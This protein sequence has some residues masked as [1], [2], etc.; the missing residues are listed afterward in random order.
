[1][2]NVDLNQ[3][4]SPTREIASDEQI[5]SETLDGA[6][7][8]PETTY[9]N[10]DWHKWLGYFM[11]IPDL[12]AALTLKALF[13]VGKGY[14]TEDIHTQTILDN[15]S[16]FGKDTF[17]DILYNMQIQ[18]RIGGEA[19]A[20]I[21]RDEDGELLNLKPLDPGTIQ[22]VVDSKGI[23][24]RYEQI[25]KHGKKQSVKKFKPEDMFVMYNNRIGD[26]IHGISDIAPLE[27]T[28]IANNNSFVDVKD[29]MH[30]QSKP[31]IIFKLKTDDSTK[32]TTF[33]NKMEAALKEGNHIY[34]PDDENILSYE[35]VQLN[36]SNMVLAW[37]DDLRNSFFR[38]IGLPQIVPGA[39]GQ[40]TES[41]SKTIYLAF[42]T[43]TA[44]DQL[45]IEEQ[46]W[47]QLNLRIK[48]NSPATLQ[49]EMQT[50]TAKDAGLVA[51]Q[52]SDTVAGQ[53][54]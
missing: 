29:I 47:Q 18:M 5:N 31:I 52:P 50:D 4:S 19:Y 33:V 37:R 35:I 34:I 2:P 30:R 44:S 26:Q 53:G 36:A 12:K 32:I 9:I 39:S 54:R 46:V 6:S 3:A 13:N 16:G 7:E 24:K 49:A 14:T 8:S 38:A 1:M 15:V 20:E 43:I 45:Y 11:N 28:L 51:T 10:E 27:E 23:I 25:T 21:I 48:L 17:K 22:V 40:S 42:E 41:E